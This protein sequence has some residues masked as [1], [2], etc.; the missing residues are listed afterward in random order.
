VLVFDHNELHLKRQAVVRRLGH[1]RVEPLKARLVSIALLAV[2]G[3]A[4][5]PDYIPPPAPV[6]PA[7]KEVKGWKIAE[8]RDTFE[9]GAWWSVYNDDVLDGL[10]RQIEVTNQNLA[11]ADAAF[12]QAAAIVQQARAALFPVIALDYS[13]VRSHTGAAAATAG[14]S[15]PIIGLARTRTTVT[16][17]TTGSWDL[18]VWGSIRRTIESDVANAQAS[19]ADLANARLSAQTQLATAYFN[20]RAAD[21]LQHILDESVANFKRT[22]KITENQYTQGTVARS[23]VVVAQ[24]QVKTTEALAINVGIQRAQFEHAIAVLTGFPP[25]DLSIK[26]KRLATKVPAVPASIPSLLLERRPDIAAA[27]RRIQTQSA[28][29]GVAVAAYF[30]DVSISG[31]FGWV[32]SRAFPIS[33]ANEVWSIGGALTETLIDGGLRRAQVVAAEA[34]YYQAVATY[35]QTVLT[36]IQQVEDQL[37]AQRILAKQAKPQD[38]AVTLSRKAV[39]I[40]L[41]EY[42]AGTTSFTTV[43]TAQST[44]LTNEQAAL[45]VLQNRYLASVNLISA[46]GGGWDAASGIPDYKTLRHWRSCISIRDTI[47]GDIPPEMPPCL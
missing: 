18:D 37:A 17:E 38:E 46:L 12:R 32:G 4:V 22:Q 14:S 34:A 2:G 29:I 5:G 25:A 19:A 11:A 42:K 28:L 43:V 45:T 21:S 8:P 1:L 33:V 24:T 26:P 36:A 30:P 20:M 10:M 41:N 15:G 35:R 44:Q 31:F 6:P 7:Y 47:V 3:C 27:E 13:A 16:L 23:D 9:R 39:E 40:A